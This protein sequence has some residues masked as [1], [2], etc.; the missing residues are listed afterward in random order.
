MNRGQALVGVA[1]VGATPMVVASPAEADTNHPAGCSTTSTAGWQPNCWVGYGYDQTG[2]HVMAVQTVV[3]L[4][5]NNHFCF[6]TSGLARD[7]VFGPSTKNAVKDWQYGTGGQSGSGFGASLTPD[8]IVG[9]QTWDRM[10]SVVT[11]G[12]MSTIGGYKQFRNDAFYASELCLSS[13][14]RRA[15]FRMSQSSF[16]WQLVKPGGTWTNM[17]AWPE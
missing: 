1:L 4:Y 11:A 3:R 15:W 10:F 13:E 6:L 12:T 17:Y 5:P 8:G 9:G 14:V 7:G 16:N 2:R